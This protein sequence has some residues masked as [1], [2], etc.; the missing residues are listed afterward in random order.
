MQT[1]DEVVEWGPG[2]G[3]VS[4]DGKLVEISTSEI[5]S[6]ELVLARPGSKVPVEG[7]VGEGISSIDE[8]SI[9]GESIP[10]EKVN[11]WKGFAG[12]INQNGLLKIRAE[13]TGADTTLAGIIRRVA[14]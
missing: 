1:L 12:P 13:K 5:E 4:R 2:T 7:V 11:G 8:S 3:L 6:G 9:T 14:V 10:V